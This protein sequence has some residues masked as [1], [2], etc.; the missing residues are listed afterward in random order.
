MKMGQPKYPPELIGPPV[1]IPKGILTDKIVED[2]LRGR[3]LDITGPEV[4]E[5][6]IDWNRKVLW[7]NVNGVCAFRACKI[8]H[9]EYTPIGGHDGPSDPSTA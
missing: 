5:I 8:G 3:Q 9:L 4:V 6:Q 2:L 1:Y 7:V